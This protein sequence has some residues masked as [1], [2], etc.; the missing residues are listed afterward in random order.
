[1]LN[2]DIPGTIE[3]MQVL[4]IISM[5]QEFYEEREKIMNVLSPAVAFPPLPRI[6][7]S[8]YIVKKPRETMLPVCRGFHSFVIVGGLWD[9]LIH[10]LC[11]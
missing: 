7:F 3:N 5:L 9:Y 10:P 11:F 1:M 6:R 2:I 4:Q 8:Q